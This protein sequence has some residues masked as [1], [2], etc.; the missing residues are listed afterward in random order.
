RKAVLLS[1]VQTQL[2][3]AV[4]VLPHSPAPHVHHLGH[5]LGQLPKRYTSSGP[6]RRAWLGANPRALPRAQQHPQHRGNRD[7][8]WPTRRTLGVG[9]GGVLFWF[10]VAFS[11]DRG[12]G[13]WLSRAPVHDSARLRPW[14]FLPSSSCKRL[15]GAGH[16]RAH[17]YPL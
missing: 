2:R 13:R 11:V 7:H 6:A 8:F 5:N 17:A 3:T 10:V 4:M 16:R 12:T 9:L 1:P 15:G 14:R